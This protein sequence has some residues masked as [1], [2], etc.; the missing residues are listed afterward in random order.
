MI[1]ASISSSTVKTTELATARG[2]GTRS[3]LV[4]TS[5][6]GIIATVTNSAST[7]GTNTGRNQ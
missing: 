6:S 3:D 5:I 1:P 4:C 7:N 2:S